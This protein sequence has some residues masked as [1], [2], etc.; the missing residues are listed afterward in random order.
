MPGL[1]DAH[2]HAPQYSY[3]GVGY[4]MSLSER[5]RTYK[6]PTEARFSD[7][8][9]AKKI[10]PLAVRRTLQHGTTTASYL[11]TVHLDSTKELCKLI[12]AV[13][14]RVH[15]GRVHMDHE[16]TAATTQQTVEETRTFIKFV[17]DMKN[18]LIEPVVGPR[19]ASTCSQHLLRA[20]GDLAR[21]VEV[22]VHSHICQ[23]KEEVT[24]VL[25]DN[26]MHRD[27]ASVFDTAGM[28]NSRTYMAHC[29][30]MEDREVELFKSKGVGVVHCPNSNFSLTSGCLDVR[31]L[32]DVGITKIGLGTDLSGGYSPSILDAMRC[33]LHTSKAVWFKRDGDPQYV[34]LTLPEVLYMATVGGAT[35]LG[36]DAKIGNFKVGKEFD[37]LIIDTAAPHGAPV[38]DIFDGDTVEDCISKFFYLGDDRNIVRRYV[39]GKEIQI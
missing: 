37:A 4:D 30:Y 23:Q 19:F 3:V 5:L 6:I 26:P 31:G 8:E 16:Q 17:R 29:V 7:V 24:S 21:E 38:F 2:N 22:P 34:P 15:V 32:L 12:A 39:A 36:L 35:V 10:Y 13:G 20:L 18:D 1:V 33:A 27:S 28:L 11:A 25:L 9:I 14:Q